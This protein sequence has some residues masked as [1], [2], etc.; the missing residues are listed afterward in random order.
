MPIIKMDASG[1]RLPVFSVRYTD[2]W[3][4]LLEMYPLHGAK[5]I[6]CDLPKSHEN[7]VQW[8]RSLQ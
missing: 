3:Q 2:T 7:A 5:I 1:Q 6:L 4:L 8:V